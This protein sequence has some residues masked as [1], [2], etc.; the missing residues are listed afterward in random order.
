MKLG[1]L[2][3]AEVNLTMPF[4]LL[5]PDSN[6]IRAIDIVLDS[7]AVDPEPAELVANFVKS[8]KAWLKS[9]PPKCCPTYD[10]LERS[11]KDM[12]VED[13]GLMTSILDLRSKALEAVHEHLPDRVYPEPFL[14]W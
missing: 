10:Y 2:R 3:F 9:S 14:G 13:E 4:S 5:Q 6:Y 11:F 8:V 12:G 7:T 1:I